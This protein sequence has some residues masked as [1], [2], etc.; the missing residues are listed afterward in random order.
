MVKEL[1]E[2]LKDP[3]ARRELT[4]EEQAMLKE[5]DLEE[6]RRLFE[7]RLRNN[8]SYRQEHER[9]PAVWAR[10]EIMDEGVSFLEAR[11]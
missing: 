2:W 6:L 10:P 1:E 3:R 4:A 5:L 8:L 11:V 9:S 7:Q